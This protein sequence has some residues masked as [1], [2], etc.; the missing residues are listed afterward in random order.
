MDTRHIPATEEFTE[1]YIIPDE[2]PSIAEVVAG[3]E[4]A[5]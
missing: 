4:K 2:S 5:I 3:A 1:R